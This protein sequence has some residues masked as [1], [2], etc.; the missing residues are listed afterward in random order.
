MVI[1]SKDY[2]KF[3]EEGF[4]N[5]FPLVSQK[6]LSTKISQIK[7]ILCFN[8]NIENSYC[9]SDRIHLMLGNGAFCI[10]QNTE[11]IQDFY[12]DNIDCIFFNNEL[13]LIDLINKWINLPK[14]R[15]DIRKNA[16]DKSNS[17]NSY[18]CRVDEFLKYI[19]NNEN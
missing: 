4:S 6:D 9:W 2:K 3:K 12:K 19:N 15:Y 11:G 13:E 14:E 5:C 7:I 18:N 8:N 10:A 16:F 1:Y 17:K